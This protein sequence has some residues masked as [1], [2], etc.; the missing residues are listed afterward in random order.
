MPTLTSL[1]VIT[2][3][4]MWW[5][6]S[7]L[8][9]MS[10]RTTSHCSSSNSISSL[11]SKVTSQIPKG[12]QQPSSILCN[13][14]HSRTSTSW[15]TTVTMMQHCINSSSSIWLLIRRTRECSWDSPIEGTIDRKTIKSSS[16]SKGG[17]CKTKRTVSRMS[18]WQATD[19]SL[20][21][22]WM[23]IPLTASLHL[24]VSKR[25]MRMMRISYILISSNC[26][27]SNSSLYQQGI[28]TRKPNPAVSLEN[29]QETR[30]NS[31]KTMTVLMTRMRTR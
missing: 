18:G 1:R 7:E 10:I 15:V 28:I 21:R 27:N 23:L 25:P 26:T 5:D 30:H 20:S 2:K 4:T 11:I 6:P 9:P 29:S 8:L 12:E 19:K 16:N 14:S 31:K 3:W 17:G 24:G 13:S 22:T